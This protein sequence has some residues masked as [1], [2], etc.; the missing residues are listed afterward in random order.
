[1][2]FRNISGTAAEPVNRAKEDGDEE[3]QPGVCF[4]GG[5]VCAVTLLIGCGLTARA[6]H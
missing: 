4:I 6:I 2:L 1:V 3:P 5:A